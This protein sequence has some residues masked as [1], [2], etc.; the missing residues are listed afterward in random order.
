MR[1]LPRPGD[2]PTA[3]FLACISRVKDDELKTRLHLI[4]GDVT[5]ICDAYGVAAAA[6]TLDAFPSATTL[7]GV[8]TAR[9]MADVYDSRMA[10]KGGPGRPVY[11]KLMAAPAHGRCPLCGLRTVSTLDHHLPKTVYPGL[12]VNPLNLVPACADCNKEKGMFAPDTPD[13]QTLHPYFDDAGRET[14]LRGEVVQGEPPAI[15]FHV[16]SPATLPPLLVGRLS[17]HF[18]LFRLGDLYAS[19]A[20]EELVNIR[21][22]L[23]ELF[24]AAGTEA[25]RSHLVTQAASYLAAQRNSW[26]AAM[27]RAI[28]DSD[29]YC[30][31]GFGASGQDAIAAMEPAAVP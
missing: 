11:E 16:A 5:A 4:E 15:K 29:W 8:V 30:G 6:A 23:T 26:Q 10:K 1:S 28:A 9:E 18:Q 14:W 7:G 24:G 12:A 13:H 31:G 27:Y 20:G 21:Y 3:V 19:H 2:V 25:V 17:H 22:A